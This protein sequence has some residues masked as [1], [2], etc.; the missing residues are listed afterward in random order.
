VHAKNDSDDGPD[1][2]PTFVDDVCKMT[3]TRIHV[4]FGINDGG[5]SV[6]ILGN[7]AEALLAKSAFDSFMEMQKTEPET[8]EYKLFE[9]IFN[10]DETVSQTA[11]ADCDVPPE[12]SETAVVVVS[13]GAEKP[14]SS[15]TDKNLLPETIRR[16]CSIDRLESIGG[17]GSVAAAATNE[18]TAPNKSWVSLVKENKKET[19][20]KPLPPTPVTDGESKDDNAAGDAVVAKTPAPPPRV[21][22]HGFRASGT[23]FMTM[24]YDNGVS[25]S[26]ASAAA[27]AAAAAAATHSM[28]H[29]H[30]HSSP[31]FANGGLSHHPTTQTL[32][33]FSPAVFAHVFA[34]TFSSS[35]VSAYQAAHG[36]RHFF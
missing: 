7:C 16:E 30:Q 28:Y 36:P 19:S 1:K 21:P 33:S 29:P 13:T 22:L 20:P 9:K 17:G 26:A 4:Y 27:A 31:Y 18:E 5:I 10:N 2:A 3:N 34:E 23:P 15:D 8:S 6:V 12:P 14:P 32:S 35:F 25:G 24:Q 11:Y